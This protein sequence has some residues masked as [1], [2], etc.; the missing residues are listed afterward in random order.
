[1]GQ[2]KG[3]GE[4]ILCLA[5]E[6]DSVDAAKFHFVGLSTDHLPNVPGL[7]VQEKRVGFAAMAGSVDCGLSDL[8][9]R[10]R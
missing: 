8:E 6:A 10:C 2:S 5:I 1:M 4:W 7:L 9:S 3:L